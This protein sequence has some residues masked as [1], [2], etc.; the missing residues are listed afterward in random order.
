[1]V[2]PR[3]TG[4]EKKDLVKLEPDESLGKASDKITI[5]IPEEAE[6]V[7][8]IIKLE[9]DLADED[10]EEDYYDYDDDIIMPGMQILPKLE[11]EEPRS[12]KLEQEVHGADEGDGDEGE[13][14]E[15]ELFA[16]GSLISPS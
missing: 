4:E 16:S 2:S 5:V 1:M 15:D 7:K 14:S 10:V 13:Y 6:D 8:P 11:K 12:V 9:P 3:L